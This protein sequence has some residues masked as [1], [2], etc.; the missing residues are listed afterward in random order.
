MIVPDDN[1]RTRPVTG[2][3]RLHRS[4]HISLV[5]VIHLYLLPV[6]CLVDVDKSIIFMS[7]NI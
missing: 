4:F 3:T 7:P 1:V 5:V 6:T 2:R